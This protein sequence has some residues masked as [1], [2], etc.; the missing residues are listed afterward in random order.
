MNPKE[1][2]E[3]YAVLDSDDHVVAK[4]LWDGRCRV[5]VWKH[6]P[7]RIVQSFFIRTEGGGVV[8]CNPSLGA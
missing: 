1:Y 6:D 2:V 4:Q 7:N 3:K 5:N 8:S